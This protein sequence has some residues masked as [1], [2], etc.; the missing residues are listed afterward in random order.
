MV[1]AVSIIALEVPLYYGCTV[2]AHYIYSKHALLCQQVQWH[3]NTRL[4]TC[5]SPKNTNFTLLL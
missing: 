5:T 1:P 2:L 3:V 4:M